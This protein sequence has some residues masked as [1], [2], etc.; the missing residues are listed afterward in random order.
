[1]VVLGLSATAMTPAHAA[2][3]DIQ[4]DNV[5]FENETVADGSRQS[6]SVNWSIAAKASN[7]VTLSVDFPAGLVG[8]NDS[9]LMKGPGG[10]DAGA[11]TVTETN[12]TCTVDPAFIQKNPYGVSG[13]FWF[14]VKT[15]LRNDTTTEQT[16]EFGGQE[17]PVTVEPN[18]Y[19]C[20]EVCDFTGYR[21]KKYGS[22]NNLDDTITW[23]VRLPAGEDGIAANSNI[24]ITDDLDT[25]IF[26][27][28]T[29]YDGETWPQLW[30]G[31]CLRPNSNNEMTPRWLTRTTADW[32]ADLTEVSFQSRAGSNTGGSCD[33]PNAIVPGGSF[34]QAVW[35][36][37]VKDLGKAGTYKNSA[38]YTI[39]GVKTE[40]T[41]GTATRRSGGGDVDGTNFGNFTVTKQLDGDTVLNP[42]FTVNY[43]AY[44][45]SV[46]PSKL[47]DSGS[48]EVKHGQTY[49][50]GDFYDG[51]R[52]VLT[53][54]QPTDPANVTWSTPQF[55]GPNGPLTEIVFSA[56]AGTLDTTTEITLTNEATLGK[57]TIIAKKVV[58]NPDGIETGVDEFYVSY[59]REAAIEKGI[60]NLVGGKMAL[61]ADGTPV[62]LD[63]PADVSYSFFEGFN[64]I[65][66]A[67]AGT[68]W[69]EPV[70]TVNGVEVEAYEAVNLPIDGSIEL[71]VTNKITQN[72]G[73]FSIAKSVSGD[74]ASLVPAD[75]L[76][77][78]KYSYTAVND[79]AA[80]AGTVKVRAGDTSAAIDDIPEGA[81]VTLEEVTPANVNGATWGTPKF[82]VTEFT[83]EKDQI[84]EIT[85][86]NP[87]A[88]NPAGNGGGG[89]PNTGADSASAFIAPAALLLLVSGVAII[90]VT[91]RR[92]MSAAE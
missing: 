86:D 59:S 49:T 35:V 51:T 11:C 22:Y 54:V 36:V 88:K 28:V 75:T 14:D 53:E 21:F 8:Y 52:V 23:T 6:L 65:P 4:I 58:E 62:V 61:A 10:V 66:D 90:Y 1:M 7:P 84:V 60:E 69:A 17:L 32:N 89:L 2:E 9:F 81:V 68:T 55:V 26:E 83:V 3:G 38:S 15:D 29:D 25:E 57:G 64:D 76:F 18:P 47:L 43:E 12:I 5:S 46:V 77:D 78:V 73:G 63:L 37:K 91:R 24:V 13:S 48:F 71:V 82:S 42:T 34:Y 79:F 80:G 70:Y 72:V 50:S 40:S 19:Y 44:D 56:D 74:G 30:E 31:R 92:K 67:P 85:L 41:E 39:D 27:L 45:D 33:D 20:D 16:F 87:I